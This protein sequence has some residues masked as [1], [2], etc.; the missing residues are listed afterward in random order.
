ML[1]NLTPSCLF[2]YLWYNKKTGGGNEKQPG[3]ISFKKRV[4]S[5]KIA[6]SFYLSIIIYNQK[7]SIIKYIMVVPLKIPLKSLLF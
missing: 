5:S 2:S 6:L 7:I 1:F 4:F 3:Y